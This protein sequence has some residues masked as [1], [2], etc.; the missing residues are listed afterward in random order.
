MS[1]SGALLLALMLSVG[2]G[3]VPG[4]APITV[5]PTTSVEDDA[6]KAL[7][8]EV[9]GSFPYPMDK[10]CEATDAAL[11]SMGLV[12]IERKD[13]TIGKYVIAR[14]ADNSDV[15]VRFVRLQGATEV[16]VCVGLTGDEAYSRK[17][18]SAIESNL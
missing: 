9:A 7:V 2:F 6:D 12:I 10:I 13:T 17:L 14:R 16:R 15:T 3:L 1:K 5:A 8:G 11:K 4:C 18:L